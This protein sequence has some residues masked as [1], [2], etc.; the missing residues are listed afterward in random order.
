[1]TM[2][3]A[4]LEF[5][6]IATTECNKYKSV[7]GGKTIEVLPLHP[8]MINQ[9]GAPDYSRRSPHPALVFTIRE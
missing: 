7:L 1:M 5:C 2:Q 3:S 6:Q 8:Q 4:F 9:K